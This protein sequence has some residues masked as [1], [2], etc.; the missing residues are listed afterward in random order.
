MSCTVEGCIRAAKAKGLCGMHYKRFGRHGTLENTRPLDWGTK[1]THPL[2]NLWM[3][4]R[5]R[6]K[7]NIATTWLDFWQ[8]VIDVQAY[9]KDFGEGAYPIFIRVDADRPI[10]PDNY[11]W[12]IREK[13]ETLEA[14]REMR[15]AYMREYNIKNKLKESSRQLKKHYGIDLAAYNIILEAQNG[16]CAICKNPETLIIKG[17]LCKLAVDHC[18]DTSKV[19][20]LLCSKCNRGI[21]LLAHSV[22]NLASAIHYLKT[23]I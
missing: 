17:A 11:K 7:Q 5:R 18:H 22:N 14:A 1:G 4:V 12:V 3:S 20:G 19:R 16:V 21:G 8:F 9:P 13:S 6:C 10:G 23:G 15:A 2:Y